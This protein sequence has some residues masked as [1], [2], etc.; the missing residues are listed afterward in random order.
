MTATQAP[1][2]PASRSHFGDR[3]VELVGVDLGLDGVEQL[4][5]LPRLAELP[6]LL[7]GEALLGGIGTASWCSSH[8]VVTCHPENA[9]AVMG[10]LEGRR[11]G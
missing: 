5:S 8:T 3:V 4:G 11:G 10:R 7:G 2:R 1:S 6:R 9:A